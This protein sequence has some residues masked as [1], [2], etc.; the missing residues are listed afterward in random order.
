[1][2][3]TSKVCLN[4]LRPNKHLKFHKREEMYERP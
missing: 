3:E 2:V 4:S 1:M